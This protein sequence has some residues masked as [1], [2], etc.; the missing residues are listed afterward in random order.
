MI[1]KRKAYVV[2]LNDS[3][4]SYQGKNPVFLLEND[5]IYS[6]KKG[7][8]YLDYV[9]EFFAFHYNGYLR[10]VSKVVSY[11]E[12]ITGNRVDFICH[13]GD[14]L[15]SQPIKSGKVWNTRSWVYIDL[16]ENCETLFDVIQ[17]TK[18][19]DSNAEKEVIILNK[20]FC[21]DWLKNHRYGHEIINFFLDDN[22]NYY[23][24]CLPWGKVPYDVETSYGNEGKYEAKYLLLCD[25]GTNRL[26]CKYVVELEKLIKQ[27]Y[28]NDRYYKKRVNYYESVVKELN[29]RYGGRYVHEWFEEND[30]GYPITYKAKRIIELNEPISREE[31]FSWSRNKGYLYSDKES[32][33]L[34]NIINRHIR[35]SIES[36]NYKDIKLDNLGQEGF[37]EELQ[38]R[39]ANRFG[40]L[41][42]DVYVNSD[43]KGFRLFDSNEIS[44]VHLRT[45]EKPIIKERRIVTEEYDIFISYSSKDQDVARNI[46][47]ILESAGYRVYIDF[48]DKKLDY[49][50]VT[51][52][53]GKR[54]AK[55]LERTK[56]LLFIQ[57]ENSES[58]GWCGWETG[59]MS[60]V[61]S[62]KRC[63][64]MPIRKTRNKKY[65]HVE[66][67]L[68]YPVM[69]QSE[70][71][72]E[73]S[74]RR[75]RLVKIGKRGETM[76]FE[77]FVEYGWIG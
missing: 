37:N 32:A 5:N 35:L 36:G 21:G 65:A 15:L 40:F 56:V 16:L 59:Y 45:I 53:T 3:F 52:D 57:S 71:L 49:T 7:D 6:V 61:S 66:F 43:I 72:S 38:K 68:I 31:R 8:G 75:M 4:V 47:E 30:R 9:P 24:Y 50:N 55:I 22:N 23:V 14:N 10:R 41:S 26:S 28:G 73:E 11:D 63:A 51:E 77:D 2:S 69:T 18:R 44:R 58:S 39:I 12:I 48:N 64:V 1:T 42:D 13:L 29:I 27:P 60:K 70:I 25:S 17:A 33:E 74:I 76:S 19:I 54:L 67:L 34:F 62:H 20:P 46:A